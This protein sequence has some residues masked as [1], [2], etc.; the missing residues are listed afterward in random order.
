MDVPIVTT[1]FSVK[2]DLTI[3]LLLHD[4][5]VMLAINWL[6]AVN[7]LIAWFSCPIF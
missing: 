5:D 3:T 6:Q 4:I 7:P 1:D 2:T